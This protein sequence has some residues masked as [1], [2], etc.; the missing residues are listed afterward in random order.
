MDRIWDGSC[1]KRRRREEK[2]REERKKDIK[3]DDATHTG[4]EAEGDKAKSRSGNDCC[5]AASLHAPCF[6]G[7]DRI[8]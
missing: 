5:S 1:Q 6:A 7:A 4:R 2:R 8:D 3:D